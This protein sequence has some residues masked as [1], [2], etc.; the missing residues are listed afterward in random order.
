[1]SSIYKIFRLEDD[2]FRGYSVH[3]EHVHIDTAR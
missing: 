3:F 2:N 1:M